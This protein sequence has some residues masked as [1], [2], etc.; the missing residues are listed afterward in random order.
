[1][2][3]SGEAM[4]NLKQERDVIQFAI[5]KDESDNTAKTSPLSRTTLAIKRW[6]RT[7]FQY[8][9]LEMMKALGMRR[10]GKF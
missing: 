2:V 3:Q 4:K 10:T 1:M 9:R 8:S 7:L 6:I 5:Q